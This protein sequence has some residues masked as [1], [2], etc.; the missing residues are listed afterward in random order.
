MSWLYL[1][2][3]TLGCVSV[4][5]TSKSFGI[6]LCSPVNSTTTAVLLADLLPNDGSLVSDASL[7]CFLRSCSRTHIWRNSSRSVVN[8]GRLLRAAYSLLMTLWSGTHSQTLHIVKNDA[9]D[10]VQRLIASLLLDISLS[11]SR[12]YLVWAR[13]SI[14]CLHVLLSVFLRQK[15]GAGC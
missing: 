1:G 10:L 13:A 11:A 8:L 15:V 9:S 2:M 3:S 6:C 4:D 5:W 12:R 14:C 7:S